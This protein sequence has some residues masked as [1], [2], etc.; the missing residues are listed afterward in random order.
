[1][2]ILFEVF[3][4][5]KVP[6][7]TRDGLI[8]KLKIKTTTLQRAVKELES[9]GLIKITKKKRLDGSEVVAVEL[10]PEGYEK[11]SSSLH[12]IHSFIM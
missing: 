7:Y 8:F 4:G 1:M 5:G 11:L 6:I 2:L 9:I 3:L 10:T 12:L